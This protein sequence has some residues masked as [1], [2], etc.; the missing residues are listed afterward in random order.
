MATRNTSTRNELGVDC[1]TTLVRP[2]LLFD[3]LRFFLPDDLLEDENS[4]AE[5]NRLCSYCQHI[6]QESKIL[7]NSV[8]H[9]ASLLPNERLPGRDID[10]GGIRWNE[11][12][13][14]ESFLFHPS[15]ESLLL[16]ALGGC[17][18]CTLFC[19]E[20]D[21]RM[22]GQTWQIIK[23]RLRNAP[24]RVAVT[25]ERGYVGDISDYSREMVLYRLVLQDDSVRS[26]RAEQFCRICID[27]RRHSEGKLPT[28][29]TTPVRS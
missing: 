7:N 8:W 18:L 15:I 3:P 17:N 5:L 4:S 26:S 24:F 20:A 16:S 1:S 29:E 25:W 22:S 11:G 21:E 6:C 23:N 13:F 14:P 19:Y 27:I 12:Y 28:K 2:N 10:G 9:R